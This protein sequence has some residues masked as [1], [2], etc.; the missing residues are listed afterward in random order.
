MVF[1]THTGA[2][3]ISSK[4]TMRCEKHKP[5][6][7]VTEAFRTLGVNHGRCHVKAG[8]SSMICKPEC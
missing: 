1:S 6:E 5:L 4:G 7:G 2:P 8:K 3:I